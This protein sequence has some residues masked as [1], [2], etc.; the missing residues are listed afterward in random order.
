VIYLPQLKLCFVHLPKTAGTWVRMALR[1]SGLHV[2]EY[3][4]QLEHADLEVAAKN[5]PIA[6]EFFTLVR[7]PFSWLR[8]YWVDRQLKGWGGNLIIGHEF[9]GEDFESFVNKLCELRPH[10][11]SELYGRYTAGALGNAT[12]SSTWQMGCVAVKCENPSAALLDVL[13]KR[14]PI[15]FNASAVASLPPVNIGAA[16]PAF[17]EKTEGTP[18]M[19]EMVRESEKFIYEVYGYDTAPPDRLSV[20]KI[21]FT[22][23]FGDVWRGLVSPVLLYQ[24]DT[25]C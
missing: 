14:S 19:F 13:W 3:P 5:V 20:D 9:A 23:S 7:H 22:P 18:T 8:S 6:T 2:Q 25:H 10:Y 4:K 15:A 11:L 17:R 21:W 1:V 16:Y 24:G 12:G